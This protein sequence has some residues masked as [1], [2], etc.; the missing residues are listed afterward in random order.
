MKAAQKPAEVGL[1][2]L[3][4][5][6]SGTSCLA[7]MFQLAGF[8]MGMVDEWNPDNLR[9]NRENQSILKLNERILFASD[10]SWSHPP[11]EIDPTL[12][13]SA[14]RNQILKELEDQGSPWLFKDPRVLITLPF[15]LQ[16]E[17]NIKTIGI[18]RSPFAVA[19]S[20]YK[21]DK[22]SIVEGLR[23][24]QTYNSHLLDAAKKFKT[25]ILYF[26]DKEDSFLKAAKAALAKIYPAE[27]KANILNLEKM[28]EFFSED[29]IHHDSG[30]NT[31]LLTQLSEAGLDEE[32]ANSLNSLWEDLLK[33]VLNPPSSGNGNLATDSGHEPE[34]IKTEHS[35][36]GDIETIEDFDY[37]LK[38][39]NEKISKSP[40]Q[41]VLWRQGINLFL[42]YE[43][44]EELIKWLKTLLESCPDEPFLLFELSKLDW[45]AGKREEAIVSAEKSSTLTPG[46]LPPMKYLADWYSKTNRWEKAAK[47]FSQISQYEGSGL[48]GRKTLYT[49]L[50]FDQGNG[51]SEKQSIRNEFMLADKT[52]TATF[53][54]SHQDNISGLRLDPVNDPSAIHI[55]S[56]FII[57]RNGNKTAIFPSKSNAKYENDSTFYFCNDDPQLYF[58][59]FSDT[60][61]QLSQ[62][63]VSF[64]V[65]HSGPDAL[66]ACIDA[67]AG[68]GAEKNETDS[69]K[70]LIDLNGERL[71]PFVLDWSIDG[72]STQSNGSG[73]VTLRGW[74]KVTLGETIRLAI[75]YEG[76]TRIYSIEQDMFGSLKNESKELGNPPDSITLE[77]CRSVPS[78]CIIDLGLEHDMNIL[79][80]SPVKT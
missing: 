37:S 59:T 23:L 18:V 31:Q 8:R 13:H 3:G 26:I 6:R 56:I 72:I 55:Q 11:Q 77:F 39:L 76:A 68:I 34:D 25:P 20:L 54:L 10:G 43:K 28:S 60:S 33:Q 38:E 74:V 75:R 44:R 57:D 45:S 16:S 42:K 27:V 52:I 66:Y 48:G 35:E 29:L 14:L 41:I 79:W 17:S 67:L 80:L 73:M 64:E 62:L 30:S 19:N 40:D 53:D 24:W 65:L 32:E 1:A 61:T 46:W 63:E 22:L 69:A 49:Q 51:F 50:Y 36:K 78:D 5:H 58:E 7:G 70:H 21:R 71:P 4:M 2:I 12:E 47:T 15:W 9:G